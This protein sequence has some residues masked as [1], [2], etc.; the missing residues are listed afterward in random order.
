MA[1]LVPVDL[2]SA[3]RRV[4]DEQRQISGVGIVVLV[5]NHPEKESP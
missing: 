4:D 2:E 3:F 1:D 5:T